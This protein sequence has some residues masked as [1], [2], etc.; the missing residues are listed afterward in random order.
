MHSEQPATLRSEYAGLAVKL[1][2]P[3]QEAQDQRITVEA[4]KEWLRRNKNWLLIFDNAPDAES[5]A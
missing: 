1:D 4:V 3:E 2:L 5:I